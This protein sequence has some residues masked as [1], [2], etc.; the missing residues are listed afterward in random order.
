MGRPRLRPPRGRIGA[1]PRRPPRGTRL[2]APTLVL[3]AA[4]LVLPLWGALPPAT[5]PNGSPGVAATG[6]PA[7]PDPA[8]E[9]GPS[10]GP[11]GGTAIAGGPEEGGLPVGDTLPGV[12]LVSQSAEP[13]AL[14]G[15]QWPV[16]GARVTTWYAPID[17]G[18]VVV[19][20]QRIHDG[21]DLATFCGDT[22]RA[23][24]AGRVLY[25]GRRFDPFLGYDE[26]PDAYFAT[27]KRDGL[28][29]TVLPIV[30]VVDDGNGYRSLYVHL[31]SSLV[32]AGATVR[33]GQALGRE[34]MTGHATGCHL[35]YG[36]IRMDGPYVPVAP[37]LVAKWQYPAWVRTRVDPLRVLDPFA[38]EAARE[39]PGLPPPTVSP[40][41]PTHEQLLATWRARQPPAPTRGPGPPAPAQAQA[42]E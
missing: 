10:T 32:A 42:P 38:H 39:V 24:H 41:G 4:F 9:L 18:F 14:T 31:A 29:L 33:A 1:R 21:L 20:G 37:E 25:A 8:A 12:P 11:G 17:G 16:R 5:R 3:V 15:Y 19:A 6:N 23:A 2:V 7:G 36:L 40:G 22:V 35:H 27:L 26:P 13:E 30:V 34:G 28:P